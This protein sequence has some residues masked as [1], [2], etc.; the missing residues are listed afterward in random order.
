MLFNVIYVLFD[1][2]FW[3]FIKTRWEFALKFMSH[4]LLYFQLLKK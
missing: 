1:Y 2:I 4:I 3:D